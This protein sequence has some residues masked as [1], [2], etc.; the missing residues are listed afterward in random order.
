[1]ISTLAWSRK[2]RADVPLVLQFQKAGKV[3][4]TVAI[5]SV[6]AMQRSGRSAMALER[7]R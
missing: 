7:A 2:G 1:M 4:V 5:E 6:G 3:E